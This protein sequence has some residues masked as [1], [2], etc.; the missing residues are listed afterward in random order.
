MTVK[1]NVYGAS[2][3]DFPVGVSSASTSDGVTTVTLTQVLFE[4]NGSSNSSQTV[5]NLVAG[6]NITIT[7]G[8]SGSLTIAATAPAY[9]TPATS[10]MP[11]TTPAAGTQAFDS[12]ANKFWIYNGTAW[13][14]VVLT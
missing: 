5:L 1:V 4:H 11:V 12:S 9:V 6:S 8:G 14:G 2:E 13:K 10:G 3:L 7:D